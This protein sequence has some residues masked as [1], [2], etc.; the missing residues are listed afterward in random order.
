MNKKSAKDRKGV[1]IHVRVNA[2]TAKR[3]EA[4]AKRNGVSTSDY[5]RTK[6][7]SVQPPALGVFDR[8]ASG[9]GSL[10]EI[11]ETAGKAPEH[12][13][14]PVSPQQAERLHYAL[15]MA[16]VYRVCGGFEVNA[17]RWADRYV[18]VSNAA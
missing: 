5:V 14:V 16:E 2:A 9:R 12:T 10:A 3:W 8:S 6:M 17:A 15:Q 4:E 1:T 7:T 18:A 13:L 11:L